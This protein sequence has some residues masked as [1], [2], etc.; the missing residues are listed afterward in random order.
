MWQMRKK[1]NKKEPYG[2][3]ICLVTSRNYFSAGSA[4]EMKL[5]PPVLRHGGRPGRVGERRAPIDRPRPLQPRQEK[6]KFVEIAGQTVIGII[7]KFMSLR[8]TRISCRPVTER[9]ES[10]GRTLWTFFVH[11]CRCDLN[12]IKNVIYHSS[13]KRS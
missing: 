5:N 1:I 2:A 4:S 13:I 6:R 11:G 8:A 9:H 10:I 12:R 3:D 7:V